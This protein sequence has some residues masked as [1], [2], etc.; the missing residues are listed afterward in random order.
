MCSP[1][2]NTSVR[3]VCLYVYLH[4]HYNALTYEFQQRFS[5]VKKIKTEGWL[6]SENR[7]I[8]VGAYSFQNP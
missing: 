1:Q 7:I 5:F 2:I 3:F 4:E 8:Y 6:I